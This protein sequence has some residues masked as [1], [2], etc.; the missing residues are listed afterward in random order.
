MVR[1]VA[2]VWLGLAVFATNIARADVVV[3]QVHPGFAGELAGLQVG[4]TLQTWRQSDAEGSFASPFD[5]LELTIARG[6]GALIEVTGA[7]AGASRVWTMPRGAWA[8]ETRPDFPSDALARFESLEQCESDDGTPSSPIDALAQSLA[9]IDRAWLWQWRA[10]DC[11]PAEAATRSATERAVA[12]AE[13]AGSPAAAAQILET[14]GRGYGNRGLGEQALAWLRAAADRRRAIEPDGLALAAD[15]RNVGLALSITGRLEEAIPIAES[16]LVIHRR[17]APQSLAVAETLHTLGNAHFWRGDLHAAERYYLE[18]LAIRERLVPDSEYVARSLNVI[19]NLYWRRG[20]L[21]SAEANYRAALDVHRRRGG[22]PVIR[23]QMLVSLAHIAH[24]RR[25]LATSDRRYR[26][27]LQLAREHQPGGDVEGSI[28]MG[29]GNNARIRRD[30]PAALEAMQSALD[31]FEAAAPGGQRVSLTLGNVALI[32]TQLGLLD[33]A[34]ANQ[35]RALDIRLS[36]DPDGATVPA[37]FYSLARISHRRG[38][39]AEARTHLEEALRRYRALAEDSIKVAG[40]RSGLGILDLEE[41]RW[42][43]AQRHLEWAVTVLAADL[44]GSVDLAESAHGAGLAAWRLGQP[45][46]AEERLFQAVDALEAQRGTLGGSDEHEAFFAAHYQTIY[47][48]LVSFLIENGRG[49]DGLAALDRYR[50]YQLAR[51]VGSGNADLEFG[52]MPS[53]PESGSV[54]ELPPGQVALSYMVQ[55]QRTLLFVASAGDEPRVHLIAR[56]EAWMNDAVRRLRTLIQVRTPTA[57]SQVALDTISQSLYAALLEPAQDSL[58][59]AEQVWLMPDGVLHTLPF[60]ALKTTESHPRYLIDV[61][62]MQTVASFELMRTFA[63]RADVPVASVLAFANPAEVIDGRFSESAAGVRGLNA[64]PLRHVRGEVDSIRAVFGKDAVLRVAEQ[65]T[66]AAVKSVKEARVLHIASHGVIDPTVAMNSYLN[67]APAGEGEDGRLHAWEVM[68]E[69][70]LDVDLVTLSACSTALGGVA[71]GEGL[72]GLTRSFQAAG[73]RTVLSTLWPVDDAATSK[74]MA[75][76]Y[77]ELAN[78]KSKA[79]AL[80][81]AQR[82]MLG[83]RRA[84]DGPWWRRWISRTRSR[85]D[86][87]HPYFWAGFALH[88]GL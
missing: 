80:R 81:E 65:S 69:M 48:D 8:I 6:H 27:A 7:R 52:D 25:D 87:A 79:V 64:G 39:R 60:A 45:A 3:T 50:S 55:P 53:P 34:Q 46:L 86:S 58:M 40:T 68:S 10:R 9:P 83:A 33:E 61:A 13:A 75:R 5:V 36:L 57:A 66:E 63:G 41:E 16:A 70:Q 43:Q 19:G 23:A 20:D 12:L 76:F 49:Q 88:G 74:L 35:L 21:D 44:P 84:S 28:W 67:L 26:E 2:V 4:D 71:A 51:L 29:L 37:A 78:G 31:I 32:Q 18:M 30:L 11:L 77:Q 62:P 38:D 1:S 15:L 42:G 73:A 47:Q 54:A 56:D 85:D 82:F 14:V 72:I 22:D 24:D 17:R 59:G